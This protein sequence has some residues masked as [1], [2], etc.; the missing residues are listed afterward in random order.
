MANGTSPGYRSAEAVIKVLISQSGL[1]LF[2][3]ISKTTTDK[4]DLGQMDRQAGDD[5]LPSRM[6]YCTCE[7]THATSQMNDWLAAAPPAASV[8]SQCEAGTGYAHDIS[9]KARRYTASN[10]VPQCTLLT[11]SYRSVCQHDSD[12]LDAFSRPA[13]AIDTISRQ[14]R[15]WCDAVP[16]ACRTTAP[17]SEQGWDACLHPS[18][19]AVYDCH[20][21]V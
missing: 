16:F 4:S 13:M 12:H 11:W 14:T 9:T 18:A 1:S 5:L 15:R 8:S 2:R 21:V 7:K 20:V 19:V 10:C 3:R 17:Q 6:P